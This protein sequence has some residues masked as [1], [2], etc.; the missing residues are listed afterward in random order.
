MADVPDR[1][2]YERRG[3]DGRMVREVRLAALPER[4]DAR[5]VPDIRAVATMTAKVDIVDVARRAFLED[6]DQLVLGAIETAHA[7]IGLVPDAQV[8]QR[9]AFCLAGR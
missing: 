6:A 4:V 8:E 3:F 1:I 5:V 2:G 7:A 9:E